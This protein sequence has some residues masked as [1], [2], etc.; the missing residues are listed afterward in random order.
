[1]H[2]DG[3]GLDQ[4][5]GFGGETLRQAIQ[6]VRRD[7]DQL[8]ESTVVHQPGKGEVLAEVVLALLAE[9]ACAA[10]LAGIG[11]HALT[12]GVV[13]DALAQGDDLTAELVAKDALALQ[14]GERMRRIGGDEYRPGQVFVQVRAADATPLD[15]NLHPA[16]WRVRRAGDVLQT[17]VA[18][19]VPDRGF[20]GRLSVHVSLLVVV[21][22]PGS[23]HTNTLSRASSGAG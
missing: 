15:A 2:A 21:V 7:I 3:Q 19:A 1:M 18:A 9:P 12:H 16:R 8:G 5:A 20:H 13:P 11:G 6:Q 4:R 10:M 14:P 22:V 17:D 23:V